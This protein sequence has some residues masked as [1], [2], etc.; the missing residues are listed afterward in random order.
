MTIN[1]KT[2]VPGNGS[3]TQFAFSFVGVS[4][5]FI[6]AIFTDADG[7]ETM[8]SQGAGAS[9][10]Q[11]TLNPPVA[12]AHWGAGGTVT[13]DPSG[14]PIAT[15]TSLTIFRTQPLTEA[16]TLQNLISLQMQLQ[17]VSEL[18]GRAIA[19]RA[20]AASTAEE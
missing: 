12:G 15:G 20:I 6:S 5:A 11:V 3:Q 2:I 7:N 16:I 4:A 14:T 13:Y 18:F 17:Q 19:A 9:Q 8:L 1:T 10:Y